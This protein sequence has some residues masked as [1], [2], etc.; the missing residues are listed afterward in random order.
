MARACWLRNTLKIF[1]KN[2]Q[3]VPFALK[4]ANLNLKAL[5]LPDD[6][7]DMYDLD[8]SNAEM[9]VLTGYANDPTLTGAFNDGKDL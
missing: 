2:L 4:E 6:G 9:R 3:N 7:Y 5:F 1:I 8:I